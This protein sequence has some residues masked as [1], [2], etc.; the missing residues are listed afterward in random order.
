LRRLA[1]KGI[2]KSVLIDT[3]LA[4]KVGLVQMDV[5]PGENVKDLPRSIAASEALGRGKPKRSKK[6]TSLDAI[7]K[8]WLE[9][10][11]SLPTGVGRH[12][13]TARRPAS[14]D[15]L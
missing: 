14:P 9:K 8:I 1:Q 10:G 5:G 4:H 13:G 6:Y 12:A 15:P 2:G 3:V 11:S 7:T